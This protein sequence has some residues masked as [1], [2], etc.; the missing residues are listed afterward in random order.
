MDRKNEKLSETIPV[1]LKYSLVRM[2]ERVC[3]EQNCTKSE[4]ARRAFEAELRRS[5]RRRGGA[6]GEQSP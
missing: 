3:A 2:I 6:R 5:G 4:F 1:R